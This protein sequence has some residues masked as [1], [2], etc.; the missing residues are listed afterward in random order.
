MCETIANKHNW[1]PELLDKEYTFS[2]EGEFSICVVGDMHLHGTNFS[3]RVDNYV[4][5]TIQKLSI[6]RREMLAKGVR[7]LVCLGDIFH[8]PKERTDYEFAVIEEFQKFKKSG[9]EV[10]SIVGNHDISNE[11]LELINKSSLGIL[12]ITKTINPFTKITFARGEKTPLVL[13]GCN[14]PNEPSPPEDKS[15]F[16][17]CVAHKFYDV[18]LSDD[19][20]KQNDLELLG[21]NMYLLGHDHVPYDMTR[22]PIPTGVVGIV[23][24]GSFMRATSHNYNTNRLVYM[25]EIKVGSRVEVVRH[26]LPVKSPEEVFPS[27]AINKEDLLNLNKVSKE[28]AS[29]VSQIYEGSNVRGSSVYEVLDS[30]PIETV[31]KDRITGYL[32]LHGIYRK[33]SVVDGLEGES[34]VL[35]S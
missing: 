14:F 4:E 34:D 10:F 24:P 22:V 1:T 19:S 33:N 6:L 7:Y 31:I 27:S 28:L 2:E 18:S 15:A 32:E 17:I 30:S 13:T 12:F 35:D 20:L 5:T 29:L 9:I 3:S 21:Y 23:R 26:T 16:N 11:R 8:V 25:D